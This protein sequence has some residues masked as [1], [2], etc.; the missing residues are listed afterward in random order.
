M[1][2]LDVLLLF[3]PSFFLS[4]ITSHVE[5]PRQPLIILRKLLRAKSRGDTHTVYTLLPGRS[6]GI[7]GRPWAL[8]LRAHENFGQRSLRYVYVYTSI[9]T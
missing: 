5:T 1:E 6:R 2:S 9:F 8:S 3:F 7:V 4:F